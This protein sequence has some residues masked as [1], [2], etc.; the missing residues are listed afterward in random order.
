MK[1]LMTKLRVRALLMAGVDRFQTC[2]NPD[3]ASNWQ[4]Q[5]SLIK[6]EP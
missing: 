3:T 2:N 1:S 5:F 6:S 4:I